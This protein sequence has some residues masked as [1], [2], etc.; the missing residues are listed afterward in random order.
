MGNQGRNRRVGVV[1][2]AL[3][4]LLLTA[5]GCGGS[6]GGADGDP[7]TDAIM[8]SDLFQVSHNG[9]SWSA[10]SPGVAANVISAP[11]ARLEALEDVSAHCKLFRSVTTW[12]SNEGLTPFFLQSSL[13]SGTA[14]FDGT[15]YELT[16]LVG[17]AAFAE[18]DELTAIQQRL[19]GESPQVTV[20]AP[21]YPADVN[22]HLGDPAGAATV[23]S[24][25]S[26]A[27][28]MFVYV[29]AAGG[30]TGDNG[31]MCHFY[32][33]EMTAAGAMFT[34]P[35]IEPDAAAAIVAE[36]WTVTSVSVA[37]YNEEMTDIFFP[38]FNPAPVQAGR[39]FSAS[40]AAFGF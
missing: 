25:P 37:Y 35:L 9:T 23:I 28:A 33:D 34:A 5:P 20:G 11:A 16:G 8:L 13:Q 40:G 30:A 18:T 27:D 26:A 38:D 10:A 3:T 21:P 29:G 31:V 7:T 19:S 6:G 4:G 15:R 1:I 17:S 24:I 39:M 32:T 36:S 2:I 22:D 14:T 12:D